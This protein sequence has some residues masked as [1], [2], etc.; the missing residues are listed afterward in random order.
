M[1]CAPYIAPAPAVLGGGEPVAQAVRRLAGNHFQPMAV[2]DG[3]GRL[4]GLFGPREV[5][6]LLLP[7]G[8]RLGGDGFAMGFVSETPEA[9]R[10]RLDAIGAE[11]VGKYATA[12]RPLLSSTSLDEALL[13]M[14]HGA[15]VQMA[16]D[17]QGRVVGELNAAA[18]LAPLVGE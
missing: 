5:A 6:A 14:H 4:L 8:A 3:E 12:H 15:T 1:T 13:R 2:V 17:D 10:D 7:V 18:L 16:V 9:L 11:P